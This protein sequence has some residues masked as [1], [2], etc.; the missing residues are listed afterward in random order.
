M[1]YGDL[2][3]FDPI[4]SVVQLRAADK[5]NIARDLV[6]TYVI[7]EEMAE[8]LIELVIPQLQFDQPIDNK[9]ILVVGNY[10]TGKSH[11]M[12]VVSSLAEDA[13]LLEVLH[14]EGVADASRK[15]AGRFKV[16]RTEIGATTMSL[17][18]ILVAELEENLGKFGVDYIFPAMDTISS[19]KRAFEDM[20]SAFHQIY[21]EHGLLL[22]VD[23]LLDY[24]RSRKDQELILDLN[25]LREI[26]EVCKDLRLRFVA[27]VQEAIFDSPR[28]SFVADSIR[29]VKDRFEQI[30][31]VRSDVKFVVAERLLK[32]NAEQQAKIRDYLTP[33]A[34]YYGSLNERMDEF[35]RLFPV[36]PDY[37]DTFERVTA[38]EKREVLKTLSMEMKNIMKKEVPGDRPGLIA[39]DSYWNTLNQNASFRSVPEIRAVI[40]CSQ[41][42]ESRIQQAFTRPAYKPMALRLI[43]ALSVHRLTTGD[44]YSPI[45]ATAEELRDSLCLFEPLI[46]GMG[47]EEPEKDLQT[48]VETVLREI[49]KT[50]SGQF[51]SFNP[52]NGQIYLDLKKIDD[53][54]ALIDKRAESLEDSKLDSYYYEALKRVMECQDTTPVATGYKIWQHELE[55]QE[56]RAARA[57][58]LFFGAPNERSTAVPQRDFYLYFIQPNDPPRFRDEKQSDEVFFRLKATDEEFQ[59]AL[60]GYAAALDLAG[61]SSGHAKTT[62]ESKANGFLKNL[63][64][65]LQ[66][67]MNDAFEV[68]YQGRSRS[69]VE[70]AKGTSIKS[71]ST[72]ESI[73]FRDMVN[74]IAGFCL[75]PHFTDQAPGYPIFS[76]LI[77]GNNRQQAAQDALRAIAGQNRTKQA[78]AVLDALELLDG[79][80][81]DPSRSKYVSFIL[82]AF[83]AK[84]S[85]QVVN[86]SE[87]ILD[88]HGLEY[89][90]PR[91][92][93]LEPEWAVVILAALVYS[94]D[95]VL[96]IPGDKF[97]A[98]KLQKLASTSMEELTRFKHLEQPKEWNLPALKAL[99]DLLGMTPGKAQLITQ[100][101]DEPVQDLQ[102]EVGKIIKRIVMTQQTLRDGLSFWG[103]DLLVG[104]NLSGKAGGLDEAKNFFESLQAYSTPGKLKNFRYSASEVMSHEKAVKVLDDLNSL[105]EFVMGYGPTA[106]WL[107]TAEA[108]LPADHEWVDRMKTTRQDI[109]D[110]LK[111]ADLSRLPTQSKEI[112]AKLQQLKKDYIIAYIALHTRVRLGVNEDKRR[113]ALLNDS[114][115]KTL[116]K[117]AGIE[118]MPRQQL[119]DFQSLL[120]EP[121]SCSALTEKELESNPV[122]SHCN[123]RPSVEKGE[124]A[125]P[126]LIDQMET[127]LDTL[128]DDWAS[129]ILSNLEDPITQ[130]NMSLLK[131]EECEQLEAFIISRKL[132]MPLDNN[133][134]NALQEV[135]S[136]LVKVTFK[137]QDLQNA[138]KITGGPATPVE[139]KKRFEEYIDQ[140]TKGNNQ[141]KVRI[142]LE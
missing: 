128:L 61:T 64:Q 106:A 32:K 98:T 118:L 66:K 33:F 70:W 42:L 36:H 59:T 100:G 47:S 72:H 55:W 139:I 102:Q 48:Y 137:M 76:V 24:L 39:Y 54:E 46:I 125:G 84:G 133:F 116:L 140:L 86:H 79:E 105:R 127:R 18:D 95:I 62:Y 108:I 109:L 26:G 119:T 74:A 16:I 122:C 85:G 34:K 129:T 57:G 96:A 121:K 104:T 124:A 63:V 22:V 87:I 115:L 11:L 138:L 15:I 77:T 17:R 141:A 6:N 25:F 3:Q 130:E 135:F 14:H 50:V 43:H 103:M 65:W 78:T 107:T 90:N 8:R 20:M 7:S 38:V 69:M 89:M 136:G 117:L 45:G 99:F 71:Q 113:V 21:P 81:I 88:D 35:V 83:K 101:K 49:H 80:K 73:N 2:I 41:V 68:T 58:Y 60:K 13:S 134:V 111:Q 51:I 23:E 53:Y 91:E 1:K 82:E 142:V 94:G 126:Q 52:E 120:A 112:S 75:A 114:R 10:G 131:S 56:H 40:D 9:G 37:I 12:S 123:F 31:I 5:S 67:H 27:G 93:R 29:R 92:A 110:S 28:F 132:P 97:D 19:H 4:E 44:I 30:L